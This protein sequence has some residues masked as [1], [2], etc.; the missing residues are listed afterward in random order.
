MVA[1][2]YRP[3]RVIIGVLSLSREMRSAS[4]TC[5]GVNMAARAIVY[6]LAYLER[7]ALWQPVIKLVQRGVDYRL[8]GQGALKAVSKNR[9]FA[10]SPPIG[11][12][13]APQRLL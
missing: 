5:A 9:V 2:N 6:A 12:G 1:T 11:C 8:A 4:S 10:G 3:R 13:C 7:M